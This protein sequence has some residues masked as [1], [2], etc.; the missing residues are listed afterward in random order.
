MA[1]PNGIGR[2]GAV[3]LASCILALTCV[4]SCGCAD[5]GA[6]GDSERE[7]IAAAEPA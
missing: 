7:A 1:T 5:I 6:T 2:R 4:F 3:A